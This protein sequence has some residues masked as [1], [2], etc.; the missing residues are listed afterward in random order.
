MHL[1][2]PD[3]GRLENCV[4]CSVTL[5]SLVPKQMSEG[6]QKISPDVSA[7]RGNYVRALEITLA[8]ITDFAYIFDLD[9]RFLY[10]NRPLLDLWG[11]TLAQAAGKNF[12]DLKYPDE[13][14]AKLQRQIQHV[15]ETKQILTDETPYTSSSGSGGFYEYIFSPVLGP[16]GEVEAV[17]G[18]TRDITE[19]KR[20]ADEREHLLAAERSARAEAER[21]SHIKDEFL[22]TLSH[23]LRTPLN[24]ILGWTQILMTGDRN[25]ADLDKGLSTIARN[26]RAQTQIIEDLLDMSRIISGKVRLDVQRIDLAAAVI[27]AVETTRPAADAKGV[28]VQT[29]LDPHAGPVSGDQNRLQQVFWNLL[30]NA[31]K[32]TP[33][34]GRVQVLLERINSHLQVSVIDTGEGM[35][36]DFLPHVF[37]RFRQADASTTRRHGGLGLGLSIVKQLIELH[38]GSVTVKSDGPQR[39]STFVV[40][41]PLT[42]VHADLE[43]EAER[44]HSRAAPAPGSLVEPC[45]RIDG[46]RVLVVD[47]EPDARGLIKRVLDEC[48]AVVT[49][50]GS[51]NDALQLLQRGKFDVLLSDIGMPAEDGY[52]LIRR[53]RALHPDHGGRT[54]AIALTAY[55]RAEDRVK[56]V[57]A[58]FQHH[59]TK[60]VEPSELIAM[61][62]SVTRP[63]HPSS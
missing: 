20:L 51:A 62:A 42:V 47:D 49:I 18:C 54:P 28:R 56:A 31:I 38:G 21:T 26:A 48:D 5:L 23:E 3:A 30:T 46:V 36:A 40:N 57:T 9:G 15:I 11:L 14:A 25:E 39:G 63:L 33:R 58:G 7:D 41:L 8:S 60:P 17:A 61:I 4:V 34:G 53:V 55:A 13:L 59:L 50:A 2:A 37:D 6:N 24:A 52:S 29:V 19:K 27:A 1:I 16:G 10:A 32:F 45:A 44:R 35:S 43:P 22:A 12:F